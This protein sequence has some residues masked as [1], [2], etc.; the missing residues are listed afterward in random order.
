VPYRAAARIQ[1]R[2]VATSC[3][4]LYCTWRPS[5]LEPLDYMGRHFGGINLAKLWPVIAYDIG[6]K[7]V[8]MQM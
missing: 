2:T 7:N 4:T 8:T 6:K 5:D 3:I 1:L